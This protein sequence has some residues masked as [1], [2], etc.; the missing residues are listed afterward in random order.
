MA[1]DDGD[2]VADDDNGDEVA[3]D[4]DDETETC[5]HCGALVGPK[6]ARCKVEG[7]DHV[8]CHNC[9]TFANDVERQ[10]YLMF[11][12]CNLHGQIVYCY[13]CG[14]KLSNIWGD[15]I[16]NSVGCEHKHR[17][18]MC[19]NF[20]CN[21]CASLPGGRHITTLK[22]NEKW[23]CSVHNPKL[24]S[25][26]ACKKRLTDTKGAD[27]LDSVGCEHVA[28]NGKMCEV[29]A[30]VPCSQINMSLSQFQ[31]TGMEWFCDKHSRGGGQ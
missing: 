23:I 21:K 14:D 15:D 30:C 24:S 31:A 10:K 2:E 19:E 17:G 13:N 26:F 9:D 4:D 5:F 20:A 29:F 16:T 27:V 7:C 6:N 3:D 8:A 12:T 25:C 11:W 28:A 22:A 1:D 18:V